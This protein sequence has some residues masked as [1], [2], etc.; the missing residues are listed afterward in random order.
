M[1]P[2]RLGAVAAPAVLLAAMALLL[3]ACG[4]SGEQGV[5]EAS[6]SGSGGTDTAAATTAASEAD[7]EQAQLDFARCMRE[8]GVDFPDPQPDENGD[9]RF[10]PPA[11]GLDDP[12]AFQDAAQECQEYLEAVQPDLSRE[13][14]S[15]FQDAQLEFARCMRDEGVDVP[16]PQAGQ[17][18]PGA[19]GDIDTGDPAVQAAL[20]ECQPVIQG[21]LPGAGG[22]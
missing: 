18:G 8:Q 20:E 14:Q 13:D 17:V 19:L 10:Q 3:A 7:A 1:R 21:A 11:D 12:A 2:T 22:E 16:D 5:A 4:G 9:L 6:G 15:E